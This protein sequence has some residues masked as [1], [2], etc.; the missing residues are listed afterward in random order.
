MQQA[1]APHELD[2]LRRQPR[3][4]RRLGREVRDGTGVAERVRRLQVD[5]V[6]D[7]LQRG[8]RLLAGQRRV[9]RGLCREDVPA[10]RRVER[11]EHLGRVRAEQ[12]DDLGIEMRAAARL[13]HLDRRVD[14]ALAVVDLGGV[15]QVH[16]PNRKHDLVARR[17]AGVAV[18]VPALE[19]LQQRRRDVLA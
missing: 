11:R 18:A 13:G 3:H 2:L 5:E 17:R 10:G 19:H 12:I 14:A 4:P 6:R 15:G 8:R 7:R 16:D 9:E 1:R